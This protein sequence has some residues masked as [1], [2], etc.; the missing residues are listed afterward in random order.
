MPAAA[1][2]TS[3][4]RT[5]PPDGEPASTS[6][7]GAPVRLRTAARAAPGRRR[8][9]RRGGRGPPPGGG[10]YS[11]QPVLES[12]GRLVHGRGGGRDYGLEAEE[13]VDH[14]VVPAG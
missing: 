14:P 10:R 7:S 5:A 1:G 6:S 3:G 12:G 9:P 8:R 11:R 13:A 2:P 4:P